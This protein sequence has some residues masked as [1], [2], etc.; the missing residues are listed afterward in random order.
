M[1]LY[2]SAINR[3]WGRNVA[4]SRTSSFSDAKGGGMVHAACT[5]IIGSRPY[6]PWETRDAAV[7]VTKT[8]QL[9]FNVQLL[10][11]QLCLFLHELLAF[12]CIGARLKVT[13]RLVSFVSAWFHQS[14]SLHVQHGKR[15]IVCTGC[16]HQRLPDHF[17]F[18]QSQV[19]ALR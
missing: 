9:P 6:H 1:Q 2:D 7:S 4:L 10:F 18:A 19:R 5:S 8:L 16:R 14:A 3:H 11:Q 12:H 15:F 17:S 13:D